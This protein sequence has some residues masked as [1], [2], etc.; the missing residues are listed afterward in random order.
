MGARAAMIQPALCPVTAFVQVILNAVTAFVQMRGARFVAVGLGAPGLVVEA[1]V[2]V[3]TT[4]VETRAYLVAAML[5]TVLRLIRIRGGDI[6]GQ[7]WNRHQQGQEAD[8]KQLG[9]HVFSS[10]QVNVSA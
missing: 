2:D 8:A 1:V 9:F 6:L 5:E 3:F 7:G 4:L 10:I